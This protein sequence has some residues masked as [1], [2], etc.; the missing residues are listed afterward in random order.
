MPTIVNMFWHGGALPPYAWACMQTFIEREHAVRLFSYQRIDAPNGV[1]NADAGSVVAIGELERYQSIAAFSDAFRYEL[2]F[3]QGGWWADV[4]VVCLTDRLPDSGYAWA[5]EEPGVINNAILKFPAGDPTVG[6]LAKR[7][8]ELAGRTERWGVTGPH[9][10]TEILGA[11]KP[12]ERAG[13]TPEFYPL[14][15]LEAPR[16]LL[17]EQGGDIARQADSALFIHLWAHVFKDIGIDLSHAPP[18][19]S[20]MHGLL[21]AH[22]FRVKATMWTEL[23]VRRA[24]RRYWRQS[25]A[26]DHWG[27]VLA[28]D[29]TKRKLKA[30]FLR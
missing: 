28:A 10:A 26:V 27:R 23:M 17:P 12:T 3:K 6:Q 21:K 25:W 19:G 24:I 4:D 29:P 13:S 8:R 14:H 5:E 2:L 16:L 20:F 11:C 30:G 15:W 1:S 22:S 18:R 7:A 9:L